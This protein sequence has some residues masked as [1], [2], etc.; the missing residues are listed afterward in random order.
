MSSSHKEKQ[1]SKSKLFGRKHKRDHD[2]SSSEEE[3]RKEEI[4][5][6][7][8]KQL[9]VQVI[10]DKVIIGAKTN[11]LVREEQIMAPVA[12]KKIV[13]ERKQLDEVRLVQEITPLSIPAYSKQSKILSEKKSGRSPTRRL[14]KEEDIYEPMEHRKIFEEHW[15]SEDLRVYEETRPI[16]QTLNTTEDPNRAALNDPNRAALNDPNRAV[17]NDPNRPI[18]RHEVRHQVFAIDKDGNTREFSK[19]N[20]FEGE[21]TSFKKL[22]DFHVR[23]VVA[24]RREYEEIELIEIRRVIEEIEPLNSVTMCTGDVDKYHAKYPGLVTM[25]PMQRRDSAQGSAHGSTADKMQQAAAQGTRTT[26]Q[27]LKAEKAAG[28]K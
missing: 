10:D 4:K 27:T 26:S 24:K 8:E 6:K 1:H 18:T 2:S 16:T 21:P 23:G 3:L 14:L 19:G 28:G 12:I 20:R 17:F 7:E 15:K 11:E 9:Q 5:V 13:E 22:E 25:K